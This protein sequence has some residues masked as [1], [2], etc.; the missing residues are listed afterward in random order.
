MG[1]T[2]CRTSSWSRRRDAPA[3]AEHERPGVGSDSGPGGG[4]ALR[5]V[6]KGYGYP[7]LFNA[8]AAVAEQ[9]RQGKTIEDARAGGC[10][11]CVEVG[12]FGKEAYILTGYFNLAK[13]LELALND[14]DDPRTGRQLGPCTGSVESFAGF[15]DVIG[16]FEE[17]LRHFVDVKIAGN[18]V[19]ERMYARDMPAP[20]LSVL[21]DDCIRTVGTTTRA[22]PATTPRISRAW[23]SVRITDSLAAMASRGLR[24][25]PADAARPGVGACRRTSRGTTPCARALLHRTPKYGNDDDAADGSAAGVRRVVR[26]DRWPTQRRGGMHGGYAADDVA[27]LLRVGN[28][29]HGGRKTGRA[30]GLG[31][32]ISGQ[33][34]DRRGRRRSSSRPRRSIS[35]DR[36]DAPQY[37]VQR[38]R[39]WKGT[40]GW[41]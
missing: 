1:S 18:Q 23:G 32:D 20:F 22:A 41:S 4:A 21:I 9:L 19:I 35:A 40:R 14:G 37:E 16:A 29:C 6:R 3:A 7:S 15:D 30:S 5:V 24:G 34:A 38:R 31:R 17:Q 28:R 8:E 10:S 39:C 26:G 11:G 2:R 13:M 33:G 25:R 27:H 12:A 36:R